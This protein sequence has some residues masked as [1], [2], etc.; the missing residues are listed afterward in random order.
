[1][2]INKLY[3]W[4]QWWQWWLS[5]KLIIYWVENGKWF[6]QTKLVKLQEIEQSNQVSQ[7]TRNWTIKPSW[8]NYKKLNILCWEWQVI[9]SNQVSQTTRNWTIKPSWSNYKKLNSFVDFLKKTTTLIL[10]NLFAAVQLRQ[11]LF[12]SKGICLFSCTNILLST[13]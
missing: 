6:N 12:S 5:D 2:C 10:G 3:K 7:T 8:S 9:Q 1:M 4:W 11:C 13:S